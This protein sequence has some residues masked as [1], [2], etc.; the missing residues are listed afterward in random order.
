MSLA[1]LPKTLHRMHVAVLI[2]AS[3][4]AALGAGSVAAQTPYTVAPVAAESPSD[5]MGR[6]LRILANT[7]RD[8]QALMGAGRAAL[9]LG[10]SQ[11]A[12]GFFGRADEV[13]P[14]SP[15]PQI[16]MGGATVLE[17][18]GDGALIYFARAQKL[19][20][21]PIMMGA[22]RGLAYDLLGRHADAQ[23]D[24]RAALGGPQADEARR[25]LALSLAITGNRDGAL[26][27]LSPLLLRRDPA[28][29]RTRALVL[30]LSGDQNSARAAVEGAM[31]GSWP[32][33]APFI[34]RL[35]TLNSAQKAA[36][37]NLGIFPGSGQASTGIAAASSVGVQAPASRVDRLADIDALLHSPSGL[38]PAGPPAPVAPVPAPTLAPPA[39]TAGQPAPSATSTVSASRQKR[40]W[41]Q[42]ASGA[43]ASALA[44][45]MRKIRARSEDMLN[46]ISG[47]I[48]EEPGKARLLV[49]PFR[50]SA[51]AET[52]AAD[53]ETLNIDAFRWISPEGQPVRK[54]TTE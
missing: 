19:G 20:A 48:A 27:A 29:V 8:F 6:Y 4:A 44:G 15:L 47:Y 16:G 9:D 42:L 24:Y 11:A 23:A 7:P 22:D 13:W 10:D 39:Q 46:G 3:A 37:V 2:C 49:G 52:F 21:S 51:D 35:A 26:V 34:A 33:M 17:G 18:D 12:A 30:A 43:N 25:R 54:L 36:A 45:Q 28:S 5:A 40:F 53:L 14:T 50:N 38:A 32:Q 31:P 1:M 41:V